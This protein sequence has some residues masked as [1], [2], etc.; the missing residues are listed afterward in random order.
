MILVLGLLFPLLGMTQA[1]DAYGRFN[2]PEELAGIPRAWV[3]KRLPGVR[4]DVFFL[5]YA[6][7]M[8]QEARSALRHLVYARMAE[9]HAFEMKMATKDIS[10]VSDAER[11]AWL[12][13][14]AR[15]SPL[16]LDSM[17]AVAESLLP[18]RD[19]ST[20]R[21]VFVELRARR[22]QRQRMEQIDDI[23]RQQ[24][25][26]WMKRQRIFDTAPVTQAGHPMPMWV[27]AEGKQTLAARMDREQARA[28][29]RWQ[30]ARRK[31]SRDPGGWAVR[32]VQ[33]DGGDE[34]PSLAGEERLVPPG[35][36][37]TLRAWRGY[38]RK[39]EADGGLV[40]GRRV[41][42]EQTFKRMWQRARAFR[43]TRRA[44]YANL[45]TI[46]SRKAFAERLARLDAP[47]RPLFE[48]FKLRLESQASGRKL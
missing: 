7:Q 23:H 29:D 34:G 47:L 19:F 25:A 42:V 13:D 24:L 16:T 27:Y 12:G 20:A 48:E 15:N 18:P 8:P 28:A 11:L 37:G 6:Y 21:R 10:Q 17:E 33:R 14:L 3:D 46:T 30:I 44:E 31:A 26:V 40:G 38:L 32:R 41:R 36:D 39:I 45:E 35:F 2:I 5:E 22:D 4:R 9:Q 43:E 1:A